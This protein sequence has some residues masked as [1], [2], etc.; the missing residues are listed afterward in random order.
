MSLLEKIK[1]MGHPIQD[2]E[3]CLTHSSALTFNE[4]KIIQNEIS[5]I[6][7]SLMRNISDLYLIDSQERSSDL[8]KYAQP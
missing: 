5:E 6:I 2:E 4:T 1:W 8:A 7:R 3:N